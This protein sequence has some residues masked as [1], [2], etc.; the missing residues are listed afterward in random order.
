MTQKKHILYGCEI[1]DGSN[2]YPVV[3]SDLST[4]GA[5]IQT[6]TPD[7]VPEQFVLLIKD[8]S[9]RMWHCRVMWRSTSHVGVRFES[10]SY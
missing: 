8:A 7:Q 1:G 5:R 6:N 4:C 2:S 9:V 10:R 3:I